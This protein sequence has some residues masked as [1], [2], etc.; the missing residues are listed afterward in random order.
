MPSIHERYDQAIE[1]QQAGKL[2]EAVA[3]LEQV[4]D[5]E[6]GYALAHAGLAAFYSKLGRHDEAVREAQKVVELEPDDAF[7]YMALS[8]VC[9]RAGDTLAAEQAMNEALEKQW[10]ARRGG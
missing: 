1:L 8:I 3:A 4:A 6:P 9:Q 5:D 2:E 10:A 7:N